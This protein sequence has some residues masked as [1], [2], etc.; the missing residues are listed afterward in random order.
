LVIIINDIYINFK[1]YRHYI[2]RMI[3]TESLDDFYNRMQ[4][5]NE[6]VSSF[7]KTGQGH[8][9]I[10]KRGGSSHETPFTRKDYY[11]ITLVQGEGTVRY[12]DKIFAI[13]GPVLVFSGILEPSSCTSSAT[14]QEGMFCLFSPE[15]LPSRQ[16]ETQLRNYPYF[17]PHEE[18]VLKLSQDQYLAF[19][20][21][22][23]KMAIELAAPYDYKYE[24]I[25]SYLTIIM[26]EALK[27]G[28]PARSGQHFTA[29]TRITRRFFELLER[30]FP[31]DSPD[32]GL[33]LK[34]A[35]DYARELSVH[36]NH[37]NHSVKH[38]TGKTTTRHITDHILKEA[39]ALLTHSDWNINQIAKAL[40]FDEA[41]YFNNF[42]RKNTGQTPGRSRIKLHL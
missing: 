9:N 1:E 20:T 25:R 15:F 18:H 21:L 22:F 24:L 32:H 16:Y 26:F 42:F 34:T 23:E 3:K 37:A 2:R 29:G 7:R 35:M 6:T 31:I 17:K 27:I 30:Q 12:A 5:G 41:A 13:D 38:T 11:K 10:F 33:Q 8:F 19:L 36:I 39:K 28:P 14:T 4:P 40:G